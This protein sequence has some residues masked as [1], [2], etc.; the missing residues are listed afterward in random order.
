M[1][2]SDGT[3]SGP[4]R[5]IG[6]CG[7]AGAGKTSLV[8]ALAQR[9]D[10]TAIHMDDYQGFTQEPAAA[11]AA[12][13]G[14][15]ADFDAFDIPVL[16]EHLASLRQGRAVT[17]PLSLR[18][19]AAKPNV[20]FE[21]HF[22]RAHTPTGQHIDLLVWIEVPAD[23]ALARNV[24]GL[25]APLVGMA[26]GQVPRARVAALDAYMS[27]YLTHVRGLVAMQKARVAP[28][29]DVVVDGTQGVEVMVGQV[30]AVLGAR[31]P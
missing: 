10:G 18:T 23:V 5:V 4:V 31:F 8:R 1:A 7:P 26:S 6:V 27:N 22:G 21:T 13:A 30:M 16:P 25:L 14:S 9:L 29:A 2:S 11:I 19:L 28:A 15:G 20:V 12:W 3:S 17:D 24:R